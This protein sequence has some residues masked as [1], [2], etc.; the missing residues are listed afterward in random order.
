M[1]FLKTRGITAHCQLVSGSTFTLCMIYHRI[2]TSFFS[3]HFI[4]SILTLACPTSPPLSMAHLNLSLNCQASSKPYQKATTSFG[5]RKISFG[6]RRILTAEV[7]IEKRKIKQ[8]TKTDL[9]FCRAPVLHYHLNTLI[10]HL[11]CSMPFHPSTSSR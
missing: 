9:G 10:S 3:L 6:R 4:H 2:F 5:R 7:H 11:P 1:T 8:G